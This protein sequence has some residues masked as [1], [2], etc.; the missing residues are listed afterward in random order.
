MEENKEEIANEIAPKTVKVV[1]TPRPRKPRVSKSTEV[2]ETTIEIPTAEENQE[3]IISEEP[4]IVINEVSK[5]DKKKKQNKI[6]EKEK[7]KKAKAKE[8]AK[9][10]AKKAKKAKKEKAKK[11]KIK[12]KAKEK[13]AKAKAKKSKKKKSN[14]GKK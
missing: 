2:A 12:A 10:K 9:A 5:K 4:V 14:K 7:E 13:K 6:K 8:K 3:I 1:A 11:A